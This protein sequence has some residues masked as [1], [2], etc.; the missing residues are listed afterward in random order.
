MK[1]RTKFVLSLGVLSAVFVFSVL[2]GSVGIDLKKLLDI[3]S[4]SGVVFWKI[5]LPSVILAFITGAVL[6]LNGVI[7]QTILHNPLAEP[8]ILGISAGSA[9]GAVVAEFIG[10]EPLYIT[11][12]AVAFL[13]SIAVTIFMWRVSSRRA[14]SP[15]TV[16]LAGVILNSL[17]SGA[18]L[19]LSYISRSHS[20]RSVLA[21]LMGGIQPVDWGVIAFVS[22]M[23][24][25]SLEFVVKNSF[26]LDNLSLGDIEAF[27]VGVDPGK[28]RLKMFLVASVSTGAVVSLTG[29]IGFV[30]LITPHIVRMLISSRHKNLAVFSFVWGGIFLMVSFT[31]SK[32]LV[33]ESLPVGVITAFIG[34]PLFVVVFKNAN[35]V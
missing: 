22:V 3:D 16:V 14:F 31:L 33:N 5:R 24:F 1:T 28:L 35:V 18:I 19:L 32:V 11:R 23:A 13:F 20:I 27:S 29:I 26:G 10:I 21:W 8:H 4:V 17:F 9:L 34:T 30:G 7:L 2:S 25:L 6:S 15:L 12:P